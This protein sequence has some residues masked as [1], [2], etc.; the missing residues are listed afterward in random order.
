MS[1]SAEPESRAEP[2]PVQDSLSELDR[3]FRAM[4]A[5]VPY[6]NAT[7]R[8]VS[9]WSVGEHLEHVCTV[10]AGFAVVLITG[11]G[12]A[13][14]ARMPEHRDM[15]LV[16]GH[17]PRGKIK[18][19]PVAAPKGVESAEAYTRMLDRTHARL[20]SAAEQPGQRTADHPLLGT[21]T[22]NEVLRFVAVHTA[23]HLAI[24][25]DYGLEA[26]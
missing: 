19:P 8:S 6:A 21:M 2:F 26:S 10:A 9:G 5:L 13:F 23:H 15:V 22:R 20:K 17:I 16:D 1:H 7:N 25:D 12:P 3:L 18:A 24:I 14:T 11:R 4:N